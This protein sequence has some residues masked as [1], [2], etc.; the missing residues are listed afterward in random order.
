MSNDDSQQ[1]GVDAFERL[2]RG[3]DTV[4]VRGACKKCGGMGHLTYECKN[5]IKIESKLSKP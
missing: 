4:I 3:D 1:R 5:S 2:V